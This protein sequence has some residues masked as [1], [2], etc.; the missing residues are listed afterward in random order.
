[1]TKQLLFGFRMLMFTSLGAA[2][3]SGD[4]ALAQPSVVARPSCQL[5]SAGDKIKHVIQIIFD[6]VHFRR[7]IPNVPS[8]LEQMPHLLNFIQGKG[9]L[10]A[11]HH[12]VLISHT[13][14][15]EL[16]F[17][18]GVYG[19]RHGIPVANSFGVFRP[20]GSTAFA[21]SFFYWTNL[22]SDFSPSTGDSTFGMLTEG[23]QNAPAPWVPFTRSGCDVGTFSNVNI[24]IENTSIDVPHIFG[25]GSNE[26]H[27]TSDQQF[28]DFEGAAVHCARGSALCSMANHGVADVLPQDPGGYS[29]FNALY[30]AKYM[31]QAFHGL[32]KDLDGNVIVN[33]DSKLPG[34][35]GFSPSASQSLGYIV[36]MQEAGIP[37]TFA[38]IT[39]LHDSQTSDTSFGPGEAGYVAQI[40]SY[41]DAFA[42]LFARLKTAGIDESNTLFIITADE[43]DHFVGGSPSP[44]NC[45]GVHIPCTYSQ[46]GALNLNLNGLVAAQT[47]NSTPF[48]IH[49]DM[50]PTVYIKG[51]PTRTAPVTRQLE[52]DFAKLT[53][54]NPIT[55]VVDHL[56]V[57]LADPIEMGLLHMVTSD[58]ART[59]NFTMFGA[60]D[61]FFQSFGST[62]PTEDPTAAWNHGGIQPEIGQT[63]L[64]LVGPGVRHNTGGEGSND[65][66]E[67]GA[68]IEFSDHTDIRPTMLAL[69]GLQDDYA[70]DGRV[71]FEALDGSALPPSFSE[72]LDTL[73][74]LG[75]LY[76]Q[77]NAPFG[78]LG[79]TSLKVSTAA[80]ASNT[81]LDATYTTLENKLAAW[82]ARRDALA[83]Q[84]RAILDA[85]VNR[86]PINE[87][88]AEDLI[89]QGQ[90]LLNQ[91]NACGAD[92]VRC[93][94]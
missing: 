47:G 25:A 72:R 19:D 76:K 59:P 63:W 68:G 75:R 37:V 31:A 91:V 56:S 89:E 70:H 46:I 4:S 77:I 6:N 45:N 3:V 64:G 74:R 73:L 83:S 48:S 92:V 38:Y 43:G 14:D 50:A 24:V 18:T 1:V 7:D 27:E 84:M 71:L 33:P 86:S 9:I 20:D 79:L 54:V 87:G 65:Q 36:A 61:Y 40:K 58:P 34:F 53:A 41:D 12:A 67:N 62:T 49:F 42:K 52:R 32:I 35:P 93:A 2:L 88:Q 10:D 28:A 69:V 44:A 90:T 81:P 85:A 29:G 21:S 22:V 13:A 78:Q 94:L 30:G 26:A 15:D 82:G 55:K 23:R 80:L 51:D 8:D 66:G 60:P 39:D 17:L 11:N 16:S 57:A 5:D